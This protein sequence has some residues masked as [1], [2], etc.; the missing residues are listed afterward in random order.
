MYPLDGSRSSLMAYGITAHRIL[1]RRIS[2]RIKLIADQVKAERVLFVFI[3]FVFK[4]LTNPKE[5]HM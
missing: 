5:L 2:F 3:Y 1:P 4:Y